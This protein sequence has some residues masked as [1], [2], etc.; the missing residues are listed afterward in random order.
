MR[1]LSTS[2][3]ETPVTRQA[4][5]P[6]PSISARAVSGNSPRTKTIIKVFTRPDC[7]TISDAP[8]LLF[9]C[10]SYELVDYRSY[11]FSARLYLLGESD[12]HGPAIPAGNHA[13]R[14][15]TCQHIGILVG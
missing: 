7:P 2:F 12:L 8:R 13:V 3:A 9:M 4:S 5:G 14:S 11:V 6:C 15:L 1:A 10:S